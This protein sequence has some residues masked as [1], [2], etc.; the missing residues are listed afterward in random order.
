VLTAPVFPVACAEVLNPIPT[1][2]TSTP[3]AAIKTAIR[4]R[5]PIGSD[6]RSCWI[7]RTF[8]FRPGVRGR[9]EN[10]QVM[11]A[12]SAAWLTQRVPWLCVPLSREVCLFDCCQLEM[13]A[14]FDPPVN[15][16][17]RIA[18]GCNRVATVAQ[19]DLN[20]LRG[21]DHLSWPHLGVVPLGVQHWRDP[22][23]LG[24]PDLYEHSSSSLGR[25]GPTETETI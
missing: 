7:L 4:R 17:G 13:F 20:S 5:V 3:H 16:R 21:C 15:E 23:Y 1:V 2:V 25:S 19:S 14:R 8:P 18:S 12:I 10:S 11:I 6:R 24:S 9:W 22:T